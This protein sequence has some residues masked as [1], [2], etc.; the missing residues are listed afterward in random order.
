M[1]QNVISLLHNNIN[2]KDKYLKHVESQHNDTQD[3][4]TQHNNIQI[5]NKYTATVSII[6]VYIMLLR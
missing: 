6:A 1:R 3:N 2:G 4:D 5:S